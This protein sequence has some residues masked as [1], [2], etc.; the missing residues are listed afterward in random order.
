MLKRDEGGSPCKLRLFATLTLRAARNFVRYSAR[1]RS[2][3][4]QTLFVGAMLAWRT[5]FI[6]DHSEPAEFLY[7]G[8]IPIGVL[9]YPLNQAGPE[10]VGDDVSRR[11]QQVLVR[12]QGM[13]MK[14]SLPERNTGKPGGA[15]FD[16]PDRLRQR[17]AIL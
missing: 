16:H 4:G 14:T 11:G 10:R 6:P 9:P 5:A 7:P 3:S 13:I 12:P 17:I 2:Y 8:R 1:L 15:A